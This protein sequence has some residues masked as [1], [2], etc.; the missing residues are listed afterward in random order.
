MLFCDIIK[1]LEQ[2]IIIVTIPNLGRI[3][4]TLMTIDCAKKNNIKIKGL[5]INKMPFEKTL[6]Q[7]NFIKELTD[8]CDEKILGIIPDIK[9]PTKKD[10]QEVFSFA[11][12]L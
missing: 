2:E 5:I 1:S 3:N 4:H 10:M 12:N 7:E 8:F 11:S 6:S 9:N